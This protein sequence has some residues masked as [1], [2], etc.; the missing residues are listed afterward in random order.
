MKSESMKAARRVLTR[1]IRN[2]FSDMNLQRMDFKYGD[3]GCYNFSNC[4][5]RGTDFSS[6]D[7]TGAVFSNVKIGIPPFAKASILVGAMVLS[8]LGGF[9]AVRLSQAIQ[10]MFVSHNSYLRTSALAILIISG[11]F[12]LISIWKGMGNTIKSFGLPVFILAALVATVAGLNGVESGMQYLMLTLMLIALMFIVGTIARVVAGKI[13]NVLFIATGVVGYMF[14][15]NVA[16]ALGA[17]AIAISCSVISKRAL[18]N[19]KNF[20]TLRKIAFF[21]TERFGTS[22]RKSRLTS[23][24]FNGTIIRNADFTDADTTLVSWDTCEQINC[25]NEPCTELI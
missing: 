14:S 5:L 20:R 16:D 1:D 10:V 13:S 11:L 21:M 17:F 18:I 12:I 19:A 23:A 4:D 6:A 15:T 3:F 8:L 24:K 22:F 2:D 25:K 7:L 9:V